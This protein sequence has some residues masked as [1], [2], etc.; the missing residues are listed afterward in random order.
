MNWHLLQSVALCLILA[1][2]PIDP[3]PQR[4]VSS[5]PNQTESPQTQRVQMNLS[6]Q[7]Q[8]EESFFKNTQASSN[9]YWS[10]EWVSLSL[11]SR[12]T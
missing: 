1:P 5:T 9:A 3:L 2:L 11:F 4:D 10:A 6:A 12:K 7:A 8:E